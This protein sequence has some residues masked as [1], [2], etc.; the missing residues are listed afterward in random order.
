MKRAAWLAAP[1]LALAS[2]AALDKTIWLQDP[3]TGEVQET[4]VGDVTADVVDEVGDEIGSTAANL[5]SVATGNPVI[6]AG[7]GAAIVALLAGASS[8]LRRKKKQDGDEPA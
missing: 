1:L 7:A 3:E 2:C 5:V 4:T 6:G 8:K